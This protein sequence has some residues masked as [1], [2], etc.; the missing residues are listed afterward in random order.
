MFVNK[1]NDIM[2]TDTVFL[3]N[4]ADLEGGAIASMS[5]NSISVSQSPA[6]CDLLE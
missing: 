3:K 2:I 5:G 6:H 4:T 1:S